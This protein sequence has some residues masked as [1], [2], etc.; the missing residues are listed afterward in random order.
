VQSKDGKKQGESAA[1]EIE[2]FDND[3][4]GVWEQL[5]QQVAKLEKE[6]SRQRA[7]IIQKDQVIALLGQR[8]SDEAKIVRSL[9]EKYI[10]NEEI[11][12][13]SEKRWQ[14]L[15][16]RLDVAEKKLSEDEHGDLEGKGL[17]RKRPR[18]VE[19]E[20]HGSPMEID[21]P[22]KADSKNEAGPDGYASSE[23]E[24]SHG[25]QKKGL[26]HLLASLAKT[27]ITCGARGERGL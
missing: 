23:K 27:K 9:E 26:N 20:E 11:Q 12:V 24:E 17:G 18:E 22:P 3:T 13:K 4:K 14:E 19:R 5:Q 10:V 25:E 7:V 2:Q 8:I 15:S 21:Q 16:N 6:V 1:K